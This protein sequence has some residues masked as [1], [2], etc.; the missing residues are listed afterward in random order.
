[1]Y[2]KILVPTDGSKLSSKAIAVATRLAALAGAKLVLLHV[3]QPPDY[4][5]DE[6]MTT[7]GLRA[8]KLLQKARHDDAE[9]MLNAAAEGAIRKKVD[10]TTRIVE[11]ESPFKAIIQAVKKDKC[12]LIVMAS[13]GRR[14]LAAV[15]MGSETQ[16]VLT[17]STTPVLVVR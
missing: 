9:A 8:S 1:M 2:S 13:H 16:K 12:D 11:N 10:A 15:L 14:G 6:E 7:A 5:A 4:G 3:Q 17:H